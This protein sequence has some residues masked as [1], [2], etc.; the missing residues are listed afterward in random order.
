MTL[1]PDLGRLVFSP[2]PNMLP[3]EE[4][5]DVD[6]AVTIGPGCRRPLT[7]NTPL[8]IS[9]MGFSASREVKAAMAR[10]AKMAGTALCSG[11][12]GYLEEERK[13]TDHYT[14]QYTRGHWG[15][16]PEQ[17][18]KADMIEVRIGQGASAGDGV[19]MN[20]GIT[21]QNL[22]QSFP[23]VRS[24][25]DW[26]KLLGSLRQVNPDVPIVIKFGTGDLE[27]DI[28]A[29]LDA[30]CEGIVIDGGGAETACS[31]EM[32]INQFCMPLIFAVPKAD[33]Y[34]RQK[35]VRHKVS[36]IAA[37]GAQSPG[38]FLKIMALGADALYVGQPGL[39]AQIC[40]QLK[41]LPIGKSKAQIFLHSGEFSE[42]LDTG[43]EARH[44][45]HFLNAGTGEMRRTARL[46]GRSALR[47]VCSDDLRALDRGTAE[48]LGIRTTL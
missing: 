48:A 24:P 42:Q 44:L 20:S 16:S 19:E 5:E 33:F 6:S 7:I 21:A 41:N 10:A 43:E 46:L 25:A 40:F 37:C 47:D 14:V 18:K 39:V 1:C 15:D 2:A 35:G 38:D 29:A 34:L 23:E 30:G 45:A 17:L 27:G 32:T 8:M 22:S 9:G 13:E 12:S 26:K 4:N 3:L 36:L 31:L 28:E 11:E